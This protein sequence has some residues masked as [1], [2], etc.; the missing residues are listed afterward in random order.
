MGLAFVSRCFLSEN[1]KFPPVLAGPVQLR[2]WAAWAK[3]V[4]KILSDHDVFWSM[5]RLLTST[6]SPSRYAWYRRPF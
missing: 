4:S 3:D 5:S 2:H 6:Y 1:M